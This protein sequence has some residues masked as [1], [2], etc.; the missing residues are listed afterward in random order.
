MLLNIREVW[1]INVAVA[2]EVVDEEDEGPVEVL[3]EARCQGRS[4][5]ERLLYEEEGS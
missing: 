3:N 2:E 5:S 1:D 4:C